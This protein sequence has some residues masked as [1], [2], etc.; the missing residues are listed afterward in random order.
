[1]PSSRIYVFDDGRAVQ[2]GI[3]DELLTE[4]G[5]FAEIFADQV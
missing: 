1:L 2:C 3:Y 4:P 5:R